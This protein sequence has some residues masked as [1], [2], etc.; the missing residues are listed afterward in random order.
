MPK[1]EDT[2]NLINNIHNV[3]IQKKRRTKIGVD[4]AL[5]KKKDTTNL[6][7]QQFTVCWPKIQCDECNKLFGDQRFLVGENSFYD[8]CSEPNCWWERNI[9][10]TFAR[11]LYHSIH[12]QEINYV[13][14][15][16]TEINPSTS[17]EIIRINPGTCLELNSE[18]KQIVST[19]FQSSHFVVIHL[20]LDTKAV[21]IYDGLSPV[22]VHRW[23]NHVKY[24]LTKCGLHSHYDEFRCNMRF[25]SENDLGGYYLNQPDVVNCGPIACMV[26]WYIFCPNEVDLTVSITE[27]RSIIVMK[28]RELIDDGKKR[29]DLFCDSK[30]LIHVVDDDDCDG[31]QLVYEID[32]D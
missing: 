8:K 5:S 32:D 28:V 13:D 14:C 17:S 18:V 9:V 23:D 10:I 26:F 4:Y 25:Q 27:Y 6:Q 1:S 12:H 3:R 22:N 31:G 16:F 19:G 21:I 15:P 11:L 2:F 20:I 7:G 24:V 29:N 30:E